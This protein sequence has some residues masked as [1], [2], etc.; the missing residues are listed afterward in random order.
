MRRGSTGTHHKSI[1]A[2]E[3]VRAFIPLYLTQHRAEY[4]RL[5]DEVHRTGD[6]ESWCDFFFEGVHT[7][8]T[9]AEETAHRLLAVFEVDSHR[10]RATGRSSANALH[11]L[12]ALQFPRS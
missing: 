8:A 5:L 4:Y 6:W 2:G 1:A 10:V 12:E 9:S 3:T 11:V 7:T